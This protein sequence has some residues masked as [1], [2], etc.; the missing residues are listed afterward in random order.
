MTMELCNCSIFSSYF[1]FF[2]RF[3]TQ[4]FV[5]LSACL[6]IFLFNKVVI[7][8]LVVDSCDAASH[9]LREGLF[10]SLLLVS[11]SFCWRFSGSFCSC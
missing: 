7:N 10:R 2:F 4:D 11:A 6:T 5:A 1:F 3:V 8:F 9:M